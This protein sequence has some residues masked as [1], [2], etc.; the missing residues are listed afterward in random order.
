MNPILET[1]GLEFLNRISYPDL[2]VERGESLLI[3]G[4][5]GSGKSSLLRMINAT[6]A[7]S[8]GC[9]YFHGEDVQESDTIRLRR[10]ILLAGQT[11]YLF[12]GTIDENFKEYFHRIERMPPSQERMRE[13]MAICQAPF[14]GS[15]DTSNFSGG[16]KQRVFLSILLSME[17]EVLLLDEPTSALDDETSR[18]LLSNLFQYGQANEM[19]IL[20]VSHHAEMVLDFVQRH[21][22]LGGE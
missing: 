6:I 5:S 7:P 12:A 10:R 8:S 14:E 17:P 19:T 1:K 15:A 20:I 3:T 21:Y 4:L 11:P 22:R 18:K 9:I 2:C 13:C 16:E